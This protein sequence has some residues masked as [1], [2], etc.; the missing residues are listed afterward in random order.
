LKLL[1]MQDQCKNCDTNL[2]GRFCYECGQKT[3]SASDKTLRFLVADVFHFITHLD[4]KFIKTLTTIYRH[5]GLVTKHIS[6]GI[7]VRYFKLTSLYLIG[8]LIYFLLPTKYFGYGF[9]NNPFEDQLKVGFFIQWKNSL[10]ERIISS[11]HI[12]MS[13]LATAFDDKLNAYGKLLTIIIIPLT[14]PVLWLINLC[15]RRIKRNH[16]FTAY[17]LGTASLEIN[18]LILF[19]LFVFITGLMGAI[20]IIFNSPEP[21]I[22]AVGL[23]TAVALMVMIYFFFKNAYQISKWTSVLAVAIFIIGYYFV[24]ELYRAL[25]FFVFI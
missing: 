22:S 17:D 6:E 13:T 3:I 19:T 8:T 10:A 12:D 11:Q 20:R 14:I 15:I 7:T 25:S 21:I 9:L 18:S 5:P 24:I 16:S 4:G 1:A 23:A 2:E